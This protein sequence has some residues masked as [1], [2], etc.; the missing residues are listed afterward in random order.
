M[1][2][3]PDPSVS[4]VGQLGQGD[5]IGSWVAAPAE[6]RVLDHERMWDLGAADQLHDPGS[7]LR[8]VLTD[9]TAAEPTHTD[10]CL[11]A[12]EAVHP[13][14]TVPVGTLRR[15]QRESGRSTR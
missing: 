8:V 15:G 3:G 10:R 5:E 13:A 7:F 14:R 1:R 9:G 2:P 12:R 4:V 11:A 6:Q